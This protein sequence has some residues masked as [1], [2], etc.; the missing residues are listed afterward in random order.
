MPSSPERESELTSFHIATALRRGTPSVGARDVSDVCT[1]LTIGHSLSMTGKPK[2]FMQTKDTR[3]IGYKAIEVLEGLKGVA[4]YL[5]HSASDTVLPKTPFEFD[6]SSK[7]SLFWELDGPIWQ[8]GRHFENLESGL[9]NI[10]Q[11]HR[12]PIEAGPIAV[13][14]DSILDEKSEDVQQL[15][16]AILT[17]WANVNRKEKGESS[18]MDMKPHVRVVGSGTSQLDATPVSTLSSWL[19]LRV[20][21][22]RAQLVDLAELGW[23]LDPPNSTVCF[24]LYLSPIAR[25]PPSRHGAPSEVNQDTNF[26]ANGQDGT[27]VAIVN[28]GETLSLQRVVMELFSV[29]ILAVAENIKKI[30][31]EAIRRADPFEGVPDRNYPRIWEHPLFEALAEIAVKADI[32]STKTEARTL[33]IPAFAWYGLLP[34]TEETP[35]PAMGTDEPGS[36]PEEAEDVNDTVYN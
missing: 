24:G 11:Y 20:A 30:K 34:S 10:G 4:D 26:R 1:P 23:Q 19:G 2:V 17:T 36:T 12:S 3:F 22:T 35:G 5:T 28:L 16:A 7:T 33:V 27:P 15:L 8:E 6:N 9:T 13:R 32:S 21:E 14:L 29:F 18:D 25:K 31:G